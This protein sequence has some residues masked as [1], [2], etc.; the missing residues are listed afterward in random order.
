MNASRKQVVADSMLHSVRT[1]DTIY[2]TRNMQISA[3]KCSQAVR[4]LFHGTSYDSHGGKLS[5]LS[6]RGKLTSP[7]KVWNAEEV[8]ILEERFPSMEVKTSN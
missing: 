7:K 2:A 4:E 5:S 3:A 8:S 6:Y 1:A